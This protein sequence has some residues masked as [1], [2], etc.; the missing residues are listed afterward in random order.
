MEKEFCGGFRGKETVKSL[1]FLGCNF[2]LLLVD[3][4]SIQLRSCCK[5]RGALRLTTW[6]IVTSS[7]KNKFLDL[8][9]EWLA[10]SLIITKNRIGPSLV[11]CETPSLTEAQLEENWL[12]LTD[13]VRPDKKLHIQGIT[14]LRTPRLI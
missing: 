14:A 3:Q 7:T 11:P 5:P 13:C 6:E 9:G 10:R 12:T 8:N 2:M 1:N 4:A